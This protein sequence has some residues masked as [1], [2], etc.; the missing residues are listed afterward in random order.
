MDWIEQPPFNGGFNNF[1]HTRQTARL[2]SL[3]C[4][5]PVRRPPAQK[6]KLQIRKE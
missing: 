5:I 6:A 1:L 4:Y 2:G 3:S